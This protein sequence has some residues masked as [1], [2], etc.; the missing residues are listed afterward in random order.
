VRVSTWHGLHPKLGRR[1]HW[2]DHDQPPIV[3][4]TVV[5]VD[6]EHLPKP[7]SRTKKTLWLWAAGP[8]L[9]LEVCW[10]A[11]LRRFDIEHTFRFVKNTLGWTTP[12]IRTPEQADRWT[13]LIIAAYTQLRLARTL[14]DDVR[15]PW[16][17][18]ASPDNSPP[19]APDEDFAD[20]PQPWEPRPVRR[21]P[22]PRPG[23]TPGHPPRAAYPLPSDQEGRM[24]RFNRKL[25]RARYFVDR[26]G[27]GLLGDGRF[28]R[29]NWQDHGWRRAPGRCPARSDG[30]TRNAAGSG[31]RCRCC[32]P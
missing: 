28:G 4:G 1:G 2:T 11:Y 6:V 14:V 22:R 32:G 17:D 20:L 8:A 24:A 25:K 27:H 31:S 3:P 5:R 9:D 16:N 29:H 26:G 10:R 12:S 13:W 21:N 7:T 30:R 19:P 15:L 23:T 18:G